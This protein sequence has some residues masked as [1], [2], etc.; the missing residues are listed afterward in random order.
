M[1]G[2]E[3]MRKAVIFDLDGVITD[4][5]GYHFQAWKK[6]AAQEGIE[7]DE[8][9]NES[10]KG[11]DRMASLERIL[12]L[13]TKTYSEEEKH[14]LADEKNDVYKELIKEITAKDLLPGAASTLKTLRQGGIKIGLASVSKNAVAIIERLGISKMFDHV[15]DANHLER[16]K[17]DPEIF[18]KAAKEL[19]ASPEECIGVEDA[20]VGIQAIKSAGM[21]AIGVGDPK[22]LDKA[23][24]V[25]QDLA[26]FPTGEA[27]KAIS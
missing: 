1:K 16:G 6:I 20:V 26:S 25:I 8:H 15:V 9:F 23:D 17:P 18:L 11:V 12:A 4:T 24:Q 7:I 10:L 13:G 22:V 2:P 14:Q 3:T 19:Q 27:Y 5:A 21:Y